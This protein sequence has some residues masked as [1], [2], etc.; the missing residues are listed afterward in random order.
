MS[1]EDARKFVREL[2]TNDAL[3]GEVDERLDVESGDPDSTASGDLRAELARVIPGFARERGYDF[4][5]EEGF[6]ALRS[7]REEQRD[8]ELS[9]AELERVAGGKN[10]NHKRNAVSMFSIGIACTV[11]AIQDRNEQDSC[12]TD[13]L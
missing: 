11:S 10:T 5:V 8:G 4:T 2:M 12:F 9:D 6:E 7:I 1:T 13:D 3:R